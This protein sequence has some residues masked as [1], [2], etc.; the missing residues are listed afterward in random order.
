MQL[1]WVA[2]IQNSMS[3]NHLSYICVSAGK[4]TRCLHLALL[5]LCSW[6]PSEPK[7]LHSTVSFRH[8]KACLLHVS[9][10]YEHF[11]HHFVTSSCCY[12]TECT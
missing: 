2:N 8:L 7:L 4:N 11:K 1:R 5:Y 9:Y 12:R 6:P 3:K 10:D